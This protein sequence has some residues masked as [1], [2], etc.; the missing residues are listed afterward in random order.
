MSE[1][2]N[3]IDMKYHFVKDHVRLGIVKLRYIPTSDMVIGMLTKPLPR[4][5][6]VKHRSA[7]I[8]TNAPMRRYI[9]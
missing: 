3:H 2:T 5:A 7:I 9:P 4:H 1:E 6:L 8:V